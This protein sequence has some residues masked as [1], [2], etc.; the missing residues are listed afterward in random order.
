VLGHLPTGTVS[1]M[2]IIKDISFSGLGG[3]LKTAIITQLPEYLLETC[4]ITAKINIS[5]I[6][7][8]EMHLYK[9]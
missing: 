6:Q 8:R 9:S 3:S 2:K 1:D 7:I 4:R 5:A